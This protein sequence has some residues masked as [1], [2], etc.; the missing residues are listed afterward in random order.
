V[1]QHSGGGT[2]D[3]GK[4][5]RQY[6]GKHRHGQAAGTRAQRDAEARDADSASRGGYALGNRPDRPHSPN[7]WDSGR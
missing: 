4:V 2:A 7:G 1:G 6:S 5:D 3:H